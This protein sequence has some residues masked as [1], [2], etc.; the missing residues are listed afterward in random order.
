MTSRAIALLATANEIRGL[1]Q[2]SGSSGQ[3]LAAARSGDFVALSSEIVPILIAG[4]ALLMVIRLLR[5]NK[6]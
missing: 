6:A 4:A 3:M 1:F 2:V 5:S